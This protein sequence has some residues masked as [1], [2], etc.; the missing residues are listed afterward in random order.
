MNATFDWDAPPPQ[1]AAKPPSAK[2]DDST[3]YSGRTIESTLAESCFGAY[4]NRRLSML[5]H[6]SIS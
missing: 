3:C 4:A 5:N 6:I 2:T 1:G